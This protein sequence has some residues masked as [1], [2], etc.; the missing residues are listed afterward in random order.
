MWDMLG[1]GGYGHTEMLLINFGMRNKCKPE[2]S[3][4]LVFDVSVG[5][6]TL[7]KKSNL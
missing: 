2:R 5:E 7:I 1:M 6:A 4:Y 3:A